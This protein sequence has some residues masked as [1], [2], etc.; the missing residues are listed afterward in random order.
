[1]TMNDLILYSTGDGEAQFTL[2]QINGQVWLTQLQMAYLYQT[3]K[4][5]P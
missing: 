4:R 1:M 2:R 3:E 5:A